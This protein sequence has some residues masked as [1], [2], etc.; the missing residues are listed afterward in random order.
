MSNKK[1]FAEWAKEK[2]NITFTNLQLLTIISVF[3]H[4]KNWLKEKIEEEREG[5]WVE[6]AEFHESKLRD[7]TDILDVITHKETK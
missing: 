3:T 6:D 5:G 2:S 1:D 4:E 7:V